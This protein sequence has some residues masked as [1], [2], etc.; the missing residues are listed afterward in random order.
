MEREM[1]MKTEIE[2]E[3]EREGAREREISSSSLDGEY[4]ISSLSLYQD[5][6]MK[7]K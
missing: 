3:R 5:P 2:T 6:L 4:M 7:E 1:N